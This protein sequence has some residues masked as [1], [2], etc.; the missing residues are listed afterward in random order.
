MLAKKPV[1]NLTLRIITKLLFKDY[2]ESFIVLIQYHVEFLNCSF[3][4]KL[5]GMVL[6]S[7]AW[8][9]S[10]KQL[11]LDIIFTDS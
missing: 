5:F 2:L 8:G 9:K 6:K 3:L 1:K 4:K 11:M 10:S 7:R